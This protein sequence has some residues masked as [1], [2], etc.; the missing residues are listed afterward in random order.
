MG[1]HAAPRIWLTYAWVDDAEG[2]FTFL[3]QELKRS[4]VEA[5]YDK[6]AI[7][8]GRDLWEQ[9]AAHITKGEVDGW[10]YVLTPQSIESEACHE[11]L[12]YAL[13]RAVATKGRDFPLIGLLH[14]VRVN[15]VPAALRARLCVSLASPD[16]K[17]QVRAG[18]EGRP[19]KVPMERQTEYVWTV[20]EE[21][22]GV[23][24]STAVEVRPRFGEVMYWG[25]V[26]PAGCAVAR[27][28]HGPSA[29]GSI[30]GNQTQAVHDGRMDRKGEEAVWFGAA[31]RLSPGTSAYVVFEGPLPDFIDFGEASMAYGEPGRLETFRP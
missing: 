6:V 26:I 4:G 27:W 17:E 8:P 10:G 31:D 19:P 25:F 1:G 15:D 13:N 24:G 5:T 30:S 7:V 20:H 14:G 9:I 18:L 3:I 28:G 11:E 23:S 22:Q 21:Y 2:D 12:A 16:W 29:G